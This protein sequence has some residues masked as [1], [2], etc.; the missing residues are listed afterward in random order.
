MDLRRFSTTCKAF[1]KLLYDRKASRLAVWKPAL[2]AIE[3]LPPCPPD[4]SEPVYVAW[5]YDRTNCQVRRQKL[6]Y[7]DSRKFLNSSLTVTFPSF[8]HSLPEMRNPVLDRRTKDED[9]F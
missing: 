6:S 4:L 7:Q 1:R 8:Y 3:G 5:L 9:L 2:E